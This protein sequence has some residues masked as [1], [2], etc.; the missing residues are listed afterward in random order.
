VS[1]GLE[2]NLYKENENR[3]DPLMYRY[4]RPVHSG[5]IDKEQ[6]ML[7]QTKG[8]TCDVPFKISQFY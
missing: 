3:N 6:W 7:I 8:L 4:Q 2:I 5:D 1:I